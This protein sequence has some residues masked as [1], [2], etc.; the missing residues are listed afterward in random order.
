MPYMGEKK[1]VV[2]A[3]KLRGDD[4]PVEALAAEM[5]GTRVLPIPPRD[6]QTAGLPPTASAG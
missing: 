4:D 2:I 3:R 1:A 5:A 6:K